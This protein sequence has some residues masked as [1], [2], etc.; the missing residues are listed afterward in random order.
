VTWAILPSDVCQI[1]RQVARH[2]Y[3]NFA[4]CRQRAANRRDAHIVTVTLL[5]RPGKAVL[6][7]RLAARV[8]MCANHAS[9]EEVLSGLINAV[10]RLCRL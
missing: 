3:L 6:Q 9:L 10:G 1:L 5:P 8:V 4:H 7:R 2:L